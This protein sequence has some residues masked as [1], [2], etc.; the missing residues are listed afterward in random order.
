MSPIE[1]LI[2]ESESQSGLSDIHLHEGKPLALRINGDITTFPDKPI[3]PSAIKEFINENL[4]QEQKVVFASKGD[5]DLAL[6]INDKR[7]RASFARG[8]HGLVVVLR[9][10]A[11]K[12]PN[13]Q[14]L[15]LPPALL[16]VPNMHS[17]LVLVTGPTGSGKSTSLAALIDQ[18]NADYPH[19][20]L[21]VE[22]PIEYVHHDKKSIIFQREVGRDASSFSQALKAALR[23]DP[24]VILV[25]E[26]RDIETISLALTAAET[27]HLVLGTLHTNGAPSTVNRIIDTFPSGQQGQV[28]A[29]LA[30][31]LRLVMT[32]RLFKKT[33]GQG[34]VGAFEVMLCNNAIQNLIRDNKIHQ[35]EG[36]M[37]TAR[38]EGMQTMAN[39]IQELTSTGMIQ[40]EF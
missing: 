23:E 29:Q 27:G 12:I 38:G 18:M 14:E 26:M 33:D 39:S 34:R 22:D 4:S 11:S 40:P 21:T 2:I 31:S 7:Y 1:N 13:L 6:V 10:L 32:Q 30:Q 35:I 16:T 28:R 9:A 5:I 20:I 8:S 25:G 15:N 17:G 37:Q 36:V 24:D 3:D 19:H